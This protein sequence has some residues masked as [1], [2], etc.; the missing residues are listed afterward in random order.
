M[1]STS[2]VNIRQ[3]HFN[4]PD[5]IKSKLPEFLFFIYR[6]IVTLLILQDLS[7]VFD[8]TEH[9]YLIYL[10]EQYILI[11]TAGRSVD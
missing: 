7:E 4:S 1:H 10:I 8:T 11:R 5:E 3:F 9:F 2:V 6:E